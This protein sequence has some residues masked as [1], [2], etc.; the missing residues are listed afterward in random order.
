VA[1]GA[2]AARHGFEVCIDPR[3]TAVHLNSATAERWLRPGYVQALRVESALRWFETRGAG[4]VALERGIL[5]LHAVL[6]LV[7]AAALLPIQGRRR[8]TTIRRFAT[9]LR[10]VLTTTVAAPRGR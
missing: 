7:A 8:L 2:Q 4:S 5:L 6:R 9:M 10:A 1:W 3:A